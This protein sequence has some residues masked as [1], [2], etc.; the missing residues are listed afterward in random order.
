LQ[1]RDVSA[2]SRITEALARKE[3]ELRRLIEST[4]EGIFGI[5]LAGIITFANTAALRMLGYAEPETLIGL[6]SHAATH[7]SLLDGRPNP[8]SECR[9]QHSMLRNERVFI[10]Q[11]VF[12]RRDGVAFPVAYSSAPLTRNGEVVGAVVSFQDITE[13]KQAEAA[14][15]QAKDAAEA[16]SRS[17]SE[18]LANMSH[19]IRTPMNAI[20]G[21]THLLKRSINEPYQSDQ[22]NKISVA[23]HH[24]LNIINDILD[25]SKIE[26]G[27]LH[28]EHSDFEIERVIDN[29]VN[30]VRDRAEAKGI[31]LVV[32]L[33][34]LPPVLH[35][36]GQRLG[37]ALLN[38]AGNAVKFTETGRIVLRAFPLL[39]DDQGVVVRCEVSDSGIG[40]TPEQQQRLFQAFEQADS[41]TTRKYGGTGLGLAISRR[42]V[43]LM[44]GKIGADS[45]IGLGSTFWIEVPFAYAHATVALPRQ[46]L[47]IRGLRALVVDD[48]AEA[49]E[50]MIE[51]LERS[52]I[53][54]I[55]VDDG[56]NA[57]AQVSTADAS[58]EP[59]DLLLIDWKMPGMDGLEIGESLAALPLSRQPP[60][61]L[62]TGHAVAPSNERLAAAGFLEV[63]HKPIGPMR[64]FD[65]LEHALSGQQPTLPQLAAGEAEDHLRQLS[66]QVNHQ[67]NNRHT[68]GRILLAEDNAVNQE[69]ALALLN[70]VGLKVDVADD[71][72]IAIDMAQQAADAH[73]PYAVILMD[74]QMPVLDG[75]GATRGIRNLPAYAA[76]PILAMTANAFDDDRDTCLA[77]G[78]NDHIPKPVDPEVLYG[79]LLRWLPTGMASAVAAAATNNAAMPNP[80]IKA[81]PAAAAIPLEQALDNINGLD[82]A[83][84]L[85]V[86][87]GKMDIYRHLLLK[88]CENQDVLTLRRYL[89]AAD[90]ASAQRAAHTV[91][92]VAATLGA[93]PLSKTAAA[94]EKAIRE[95]NQAADLTQLDSQAAELE[96]EFFALRN[97]LTTTLA[98][99]SGSAKALAEHNAASAA[100]VDWVHIRKITAQLDHLLSL[101]DLASSTLYRDHAAL[102]Q[103]AFGDAA[104]V[105]RQQCDDYAFEDALVTLRAAMAKAPAGH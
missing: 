94:L 12:W 42:L 93:T 23:A 100:E 80:A 103:T 98:E 30:L 39:A 45:E 91:K 8:A 33:R 48:L 52:G 92:G 26:A 88:F 67:A 104:V 7:H 46:R 18:F 21:L 2:Q 54:V 13:R 90:Q 105:M 34:S 72:Q 96:A 22:L 36:D 28:L 20:I 75:L 14:L 87:Q 41:S 71:G 70:G 66:N 49:R 68:P 55:A 74:M 31:E 62:V 1:A 60:R 38:F 4:S 86:V 53:Q 56:F 16:A 84:G 19:E 65:A 57:L 35:G 40:L 69:V 73:N 101:N 83:A 29:V 15:R 25:L 6:E 85:K 3:E 59:F 10:D 63:L 76:T 102:L 89:A 24:L 51:M 43:E 44:G 81:E 61:L 64:L 58:G 99:S 9:I 97:S 79:K 5:D 77:A 95:V 27:K 32:D 17:K 50:S 82:V 37:Q 47:D 11:E 78:M